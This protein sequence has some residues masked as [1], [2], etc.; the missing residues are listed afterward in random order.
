MSPPLVTVF[1]LSIIA[2]WLLLIAALLQRDYF[3]Q[4]LQLRESQVLETERQQ[5]FLGI[6]YRE[7]RIGYVKNRLLPAPSGFTLHEEA[8]MKLNILNESHP[9]NMRMEARLN[10]GMI[11]EHFDFRF[12]SPFYAM[13]AQG[14][15]KGN[16]VH[17]TLYTG[18]EKIT[19][20]IRLKNPPF[21]A[22][23][24]RAYLLKQNL[25]EGDKIKVPYFDPVS[26][27][28][29]DTIM[30]Y[31][32]FEKELIHGRVYKLHHFVESYSGITINSWL[33]QEGKVFKEES[34]AG[35]V[36]IAEPEFKATDI[37]DMGREIL[38][39]V[40][41]PLHGEM[42][43]LTNLASIS[44]QLELP[45]TTEFSLNQ[46]R[47]VYDADRHLLTVRRENLPAPAAPV[48]QD[49]GTA[50][51]P[52]PY[53]QSE[54]K[55]IKEMGQ[56][57]AGNDTLPLEKVRLLAT[58]VFENLEKRPVI[59]IPDAITTLNTRQGDCNE[60]ASLFAALARSQGIPT[61]IV[62][63]V[64]FHA[65]A[66]YYHA[67]N[68]VC[69]D[70]SWLSLDTTKNQLPADITH[71]KFVEGETAEQIR[72]GALLGKLRIEVLSP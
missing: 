45:E 58:W 53:I 33:D 24:Q 15:V 7:E 31:K 12:S 67:W 60:H 56:A 61:R 32:G 19:D 11:L 37:A 38:S 44:Y 28:G 66:F 26:L 59:G 13:E 49:S 42:P 70:G 62:A 68:E 27:T 35:F 2:I 18:K 29:K 55:L 40:S 64:T 69:L 8:F 36:F 65:G 22:T 47:Q 51:E 54:H 72:I 41:V 63:G 25:K 57:V 71:I 17:L 46:D 39:D 6:Y 1:R 23:N 16:D 34:P 21:L 5:S 9:V 14:E 43:S 48:C 20:I 30:E 10:S 3:V 50:L 4:E 52:T